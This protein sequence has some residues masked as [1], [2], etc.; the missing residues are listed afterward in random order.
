MRERDRSE[1]IRTN[2]ADERKRAPERAPAAEVEGRRAFA[3]VAGGEDP[4][5]IAAPLLRSRF[6]SVN[7][8]RWLDPVAVHVDG[9]QLSLETGDRADAR[10]LRRHFL[11]GIRD[12]LREVGYSGEIAIRSA[13]EARDET[14]RGRRDAIDSRYTFERFVVGESNRFAHDAAR[15]VAERPGRIHNPL[16]LHGGVGLGKTHLATAIAQVACEHVGRRGAVVFSADRFLSCLDASHG[17]GPPPLDD[18]AAEARVAVFDDVQLLTRTDRVVDALFGWLDD[19]IGRGCQ[20]VLTCDLPP[21][22]IPSL[23]VRLRSRCEATF[24]TEILAPDLELRREIVRRRAE[25]AGTPIPDEVVDFVA[26]S[27]D[28]SVRALEGAFNRVRELAESTARSLT[29]ALAKQALASR[30]TPIPPPDLDTIA[31]VVAAAFDLSVRDLR[32]RRRRDRAASLA[33]QV[34]VHV[35]RRVSGRPLSEIAF[36]LGFRDHS[37]AAHACTALRGRLEADRELARRVDE[38]ERRLGATAMR[39]G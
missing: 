31:G 21:P 2:I 27:E 3:R 10:R 11:P 12:A 6:G 8:A 23:A 14:A 38:L 28:A 35:A 1:G 30:R 36:D 9:V 7:Y 39:L 34:A 18:A 24:A 4:W 16:Y 22:A 20:V 32:T 29:L 25:A 19:L 26:S 13:D 17:S 15:R 37:V 33:R 5:T